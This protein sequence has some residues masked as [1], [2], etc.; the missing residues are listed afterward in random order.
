MVGRPLL[1]KLKK[2]A[3]LINTSRGEVV[4]ERDL[5]KIIKKRPDLRVALDVLSGEVNNSHLKSRLLRLH[6]AGKIIVSPHIAGA[7]VESQ[8]KAALIALSLLKRKLSANRLR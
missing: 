4:C 6:D 8:K 3:S 2:G 7:T 5:V 1:K